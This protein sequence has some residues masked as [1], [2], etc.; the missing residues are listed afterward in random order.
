MNHI[1]TTPSLYHG[2]FFFFFAG[3][4]HGRRSLCKQRIASLF[5]R[6]LIEGFFLHSAIVYTLACKHD[7]YC[8]R[9][10]ERKRERPS[11][12]TSFTI[13]LVWGLGRSWPQKRG[14]NKRDLVYLPTSL[15]LLQYATGRILSLC[16]SAL[17]NAMNKETKIEVS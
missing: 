9:E 6:S 5:V 3:S 16:L 8:D 12:P 4:G 2:V 15:T 7:D 1:H 11:P 14:K 13:R 10:S 17:G